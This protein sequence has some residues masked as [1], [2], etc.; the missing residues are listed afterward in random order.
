M[1]SDDR[2]AM[3][4]NMARLRD[5][6]LRGASGMASDHRVPRMPRGFHRLQVSHF[7]SGRCDDPE[8]PNLLRSCSVGASVMP[9]YAE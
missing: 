1:R 9:S 3:G 7:W 4:R 6:V 2:A 8:Y 5:A